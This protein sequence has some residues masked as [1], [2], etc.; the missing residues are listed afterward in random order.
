M[1]EN[2]NYMMDDMILNPQQYNT[3]VGNDK[4]AVSWLPT[5]TFQIKDKDQTSKTLFNNQQ[6]PIKQELVKLRFGIG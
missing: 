2:G 3:F 1:T 4:D 5:L 6:L